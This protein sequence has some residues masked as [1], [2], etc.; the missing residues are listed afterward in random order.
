MTKL[1]GYFGSIKVASED[2]L[3]TEQKTGERLE[4]VGCQTL[5][6]GVPDEA[7]SRLLRLI[8]RTLERVLTEESAMLIDYRSRSSG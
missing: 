6:I 1:C 3:S 2:R 5:Q 7:S 4:S 8:A